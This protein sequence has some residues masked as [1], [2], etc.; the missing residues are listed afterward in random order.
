[1]NKIIFILAFLLTTTF[2]SCCQNFFGT[3]TPPTE[4]TVKYG[5]LYNWYAATDVREIA[6]IGWGV[7][8]FEEHSILAEYLGATLSGFYFFSP[9]TVG[10][11]LKETGLT[12]WNTPNTGATNSAGFNAR[13][14]G[15]RE[16]SGSF[17]LLKDGN[18]FFSSTEYDADQA[19]GTNIR[20]NADFAQTLQPFKKHG[21]P[22]RLLK[23]TTTL[24]D[25]ETGT[26]TGNDGKIYSTICI[27]TQEWLADNLA[28]T[29][30][31]NLDWITG[32]DGGV[33]TPIS[34]AAWA[35]LT[36]EAMC[37]YDD[38]ETNAIF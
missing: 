32:Y 28:E 24:S 11:Q 6:A 33:Y 7:P 2:S 3:H 34:N 16:T 4:F 29:K 15:Y 36:T 14:S 1:M 17:F 37:A 21:N 30:F 8:T 27:G 9:N 18:T 23:T 35:A 12:H 31:A 13:G 38:D 26:Y 10:G 19:Q 20:Y 5:Y 25:G 22:I